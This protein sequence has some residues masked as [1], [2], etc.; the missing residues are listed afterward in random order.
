MSPISQSMSD[1]ASSKMDLDSES[2]TTK[3]IDRCPECGDVFY[4]GITSSHACFDRKKSVSPS[5]ESPSPEATSYELNRLQSILD[6]KPVIDNLSFT[7]EIYSIWQRNNFKRH[8]RPRVVETKPIETNSETYT[9]KE[10]QNQTPIQNKEIHDEFSFSP[11]DN[12][13]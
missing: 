1:N 10:I 9:Q 3:S 5:R 7:E 11:Y 4:S 6:I 8:V 12:F 13:F 2:F